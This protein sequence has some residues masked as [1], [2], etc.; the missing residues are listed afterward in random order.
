MTVTR[1][2]SGVLNSSMSPGFRRRSLQRRDLERMRLPYRFWH[3]KFDLIPNDDMKA[4]VKRFVSGMGNTLSPGE[5]ME[6]GYSMFIYGNNDMGKTSMASVIAKESRRRGFSCFFTRAMTLR[7]A[8]MRGEMFNE[9][10]S[11]LRRC[12][13]VDLLVLDDIGKEGKSEKSLTV[14]ANG[15]ERL[16]EELLRERSAQQRSTIVT[17]NVKPEKL[18]DAYSVSMIKMMTESYVVVRTDASSQRI[19][20]QQRVLDFFDMGGN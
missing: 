11:V 14:G 8:V 9:S 5:A 1:E 13:T 10:V 7:D 17:S 2:V 15:F 12:E 3:S 4:Y 16:V 6:N 19:K 18:V 20:G